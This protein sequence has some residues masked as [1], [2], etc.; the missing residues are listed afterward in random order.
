MLMRPSPNTERSSIRR[1]Y[2]ATKGR[3]G[4][5]SSS[6]HVVNQTIDHSLKKKEEMVALLGS[7]FSSG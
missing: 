3:V 4:I 5:G 6:S 1:L 7:I 2:Y